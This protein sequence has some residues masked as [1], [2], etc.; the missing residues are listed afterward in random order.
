MAKR[1]TGKT[2]EEVNIMGKKYKV[3]KNVASTL[4]Q[5]AEALHAHEVAL[6][7]WVHKE[8]GEPKL[9]KEELIGFRNSLKEYSMQIP[10]SENIL[11]RMQEIDNQM[12]KDI[13]EK[14]STE[15][16]QSKDKK[17]QGVKE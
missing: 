2:K 13:K 15:E 4:K 16:N 12:L 9:N 17:E 10:E 14:K 7:T 3:D 5:I 8:F 1:K 6:L 11:K